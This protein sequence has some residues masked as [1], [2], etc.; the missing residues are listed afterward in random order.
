MYL[1]NYIN[2]VIKNR[3]LFSLLVLFTAIYGPRLQPRLPTSVRQLFNNPWF[4]SLIMFIVVFIARRDIKVSIFV[5]VAFISVLYLI[6]MTQMVE[7]FEQEQEEQ[8]LEQFVTYGR[9]LADCANYKSEEDSKKDD[10]Q[11]T[12]PLN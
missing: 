7:M 10:S 9:P 6:Q 11:Q 5:T 12:Y 3:Y 1:F 4:R 8:E 2:S